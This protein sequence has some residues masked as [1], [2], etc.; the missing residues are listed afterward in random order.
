MLW[1]IIVILLILWL[2]GFF[3]RNISPSFPQTGSW[4]H[5]LIVIVVI[6]VVLRLLGIA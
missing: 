4:I 6:L 2:L 3:G 5:I 1:T